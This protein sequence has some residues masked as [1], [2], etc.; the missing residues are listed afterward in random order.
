MDRSLPSNKMNG[1]ECIDNLFNVTTTVSSFIPLP[2]FGT[3]N[4]NTF[5]LSTLKFL[6]SYQFQQNMSENIC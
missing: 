1:L 4:I 6:A 2:Q 5:C 3:T